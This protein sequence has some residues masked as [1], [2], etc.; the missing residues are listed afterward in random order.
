MSKRLI[1]LGQRDLTARK[2]R[3]SLISINL[4]FKVKG[5]NEATKRSVEERCS[6][7]GSWV[8]L[9]FQ[10]WKMKRNQQRASERAPPKQAESPDR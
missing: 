6:K 8:T 5:V 3:L 4:V 7:P 10:V 1:V 2:T 9:T